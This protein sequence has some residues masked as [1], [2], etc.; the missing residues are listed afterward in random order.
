MALNI[1]GP[2][3][4]GINPS[5]SRPADT[6]DAGAADTFFQPCSSPSA[7]DGTVVSYRWLNKFL[8]TM[9]RATRGM[10]VADDPASD[11]LLLEAI[12]RGA[13]LR[14]VGTGV[15]LY[16]GQDSAKAHLI[17]RLIAGSN[18]TITAVEGPAGEFGV[19]LA[20]TALPGGG[21]GNP[22]VNVGDGADVYKGLNVSS[23]E[24]I[25][26]VKGI[27]P[28][29]SVVN[30][31]NIEIG[32]SGAAYTL[33]LRAPGST[34]QLAPQ[35]ILSLTDEPNPAALDKVILGKAADGALRSATV[36]AMRGS[37]TGSIVASG[38]ATVT[39][40]V[41]MTGAAGSGCTLTYDL[42]LSKIGVAFSSALASTRYHVQAWR[43]LPGTGAQGS[44][45]TISNK[46]TSGFDLAT[47]D[48][49]GGS[50]QWHF[51]VTLIA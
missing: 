30:G 51:H 50:T 42:T 24:E 38:Y 36:A 47:Y 29:A 2:Y 15:D 31:D 20:V 34:G 3:G 28:V 44:D 48:D 11:D 23:Q 40:R 12:R 37:P 26:G 46:T 8:A 45:F 32:V 41:S 19:R 5:T 43:A 49:G 18:L 16:R 1:F 13:T 25:R 27:G 9:R 33:L 7:R 10:G 17:S 35:T 4:A 22:L 14:N 39:P 21:D 6:G